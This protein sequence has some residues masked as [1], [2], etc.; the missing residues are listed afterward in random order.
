MKRLF[1]TVLLVCLIGCGGSGASSVTVTF[2]PAGGATG[3]VYGVT[4][5]ATFS[6]T[7]TAPSDWSTVFT[8]TV[9]DDTTNLCTSYDYDETGNVVT[10]TH[11]NLSKDTQHTVTISGLSGVTD[12]SVTFTTVSGL[13]VFITS[14]THN[15]NFSGLN[16]ADDFCA[17]RAAAAGISGTFS[18]WLSADVVGATPAVNAVDRIVDGQY[19]RTDGQIIA[20]SLTELLSGTLQNP[21]DRDESENQ[22][23]AELNV[24]TGSWADGT[25]CETDNCDGWITDLGGQD[26]IVGSSNQTT[27]NKWNFNDVSYNCDE[28]LHIYCFQISD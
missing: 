7:I 27:D 5:T 3:Q 11:G 12:G 18:A 10:C 1:L 24:W 22:V 15:G 16:G 13:T 21:I 26:S 14:T 2:L 19:V 17:A 28:V 6:N 9:T 8:V 23:S 20:S 25:V 4:I